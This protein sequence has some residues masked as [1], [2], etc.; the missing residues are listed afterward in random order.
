MIDDLADDPTVSV[1]DSINIGTL[2]KNKTTDIVGL[3]VKFGMRESLS[4]FSGIS[5]EKSLLILCGSTLK[6]WAAIEWKPV[7][8][9]VD[10]H[11]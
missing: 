6:W 2:V 7:F 1:Y 10:I 11:E 9:N 3:V 8:K 4:S 5:Y